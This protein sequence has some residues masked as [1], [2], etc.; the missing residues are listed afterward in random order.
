MKSRAGIMILIFAMLAG[1]ETGAQKFET[2]LDTLAANHQ[3]EKI[4]IHY[5]KE[6]Y[7]AGETIWFKAYLYQDG[8]PSASSNNLF[9]QFTDSKG[10]LVSNK[11]FPVMG[12]VVKGSIRVPD[13][14]PQ[15]NYYIRALTPAMKNYEESFIYKKNIFVFKPST[16][17]IEKTQSPTVSVQFFPE[18]GHLV[19]GIL[20]VLAFKAV[21]QWG[22]PAEV[23]GVVRLEDG[24]TIASFKTYHDGIGK[25]QFK[26]QAGK[27]YIAEVETGAG[28]RTYT[29]PEV[30]TSGINLKVQDEK[31]GKKFQ[32]SRSVKD[33]I[34]FETIWLVAEINNHMVYENEIKFDA[35]YPSII[36]HLLT[37][38]LPSGILHFTVFNKDGI[39][40][41]ERLSFVDNHEY[42]SKADMTLLKTSTE[43][44]G[45][46]SIELS[47]PDLIQRS[48]SVSIT[49][50]PGSSFND[51]DNILSRL[52]LTSDL[53]G[54]VHNPAWYFT[55]T[56]D[57]TKQA[58]DNLMLTHGWSRFNW[59]K[60]LANEF[61]AGKIADQPFISVSGKVVDDKTK[62]PLPGGKLNFY[63]E[64]EDSTSL[65]L[66]AVVDDAGRFKID[67]LMFGGKTSLYYVF[68]DKKGKERPALVMIDDN[69]LTRAIETLPSG[70]PENSIGRDLNTA[71]SKEEIRTRN[72]YVKNF[73]DEV[74]ELEKVTVEAKSNKRP[75]EI[76]NEKYSSGV[77]RSPGKVTL[78]NINDPANDR[79]MNVVDYIKNRVPQVE[80]QGGQFVNR[81]NMSLRTGQKWAVGVFLN[82]VPSDIFQL[83]ILRV[84]DVA[85]VKFFEAGFVGVG[86]AYPGGALS[87]YTKER[88]V[89]KEKPDKLD[90]VVYK[91]YSIS[92]Q[93]YMPD[94]NNK[95]IKQPT[96]D[97]RTTLY[98]NPDVYTDLETKSIRLNFFNSDFSKKFKVVVEGFDAAGKLIHLERIIGN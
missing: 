34:Q 44:R 9:L 92:K 33:K 42:A 68:S 79:S 97:N 54:S 38:S 60:I 51:N 73:L 21:D 3:P 84:G 15:G 41:A 66:E 36:G 24:T 64:A 67:S 20:S 10:K 57:S 53:K 31:G 74:K 12:A 50:L 86:S 71:V 75:A 55:N 22:I 70:I 23:N 47:F 91:G 8:Q 35:D 88:M 89:E 81:K 82:E 90:Y 59:T 6:Y 52:L 56:S 26:P 40:L 78:D 93:F 65:N 13:S 80:L 16:A 63:L 17:A 61:P 30:K 46:N 85:L 45:E 96:T 7:V 5:D 19:D 69:E 62:E 94:Y 29:L 77:F 11:M 14:L 49:D 1:P 43:K 39:P 37:D 2:A 76:V 48:C 83:R 25:V 32:L 28:K 95:E 87:V 98:W 72:E 58:L 27:K 18:S 4:Y